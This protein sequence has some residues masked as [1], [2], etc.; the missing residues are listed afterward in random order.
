[1]TLDCVGLFV[2]E[3]FGAPLFPQFTETPLA[4]TLVEPIPV[5]EAVAVLTSV[6]ELPGVQESALAPTVKTTVKGLD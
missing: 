6:A 2:I 5:A 1:V 3:R 4:V